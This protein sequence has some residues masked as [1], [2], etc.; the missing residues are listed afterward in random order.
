M[1]PGKIKRR[2]KTLYFDGY[3]PAEIFNGQ[4]LPYQRVRFSCLTADPKL[5]RS[6]AQ[7]QYQALLEKR[8]RDAGPRPLL[9]RE[10]FMQTF[11][12]EWIK[13]RRRKGGPKMAESRFLQHIDPV[14]G[15]LALDQ[16][17]PS[18][19]R[20]LR[21]AL[22]AKKRPHTDRLLSPLTVRH[23]LA[24]VKCL[25]RYAVEEAQVL[26]KS[27][28]TRTLLPPIPPTPRRPL[29]EEQEAAILAVARP[30]EAF[31]IRLAV[32]SGLRWGE[33]RTLHRR[34]VH[35]EP[36]PHL[37][38]DSRNEKTG[39]V[40]VVPLVPEAEAMIQ[41]RLAA[42]DSLM[43]SPFQARNACWFVHR[44]SAQVGFHW[45]FHQTRHAFV[46]RSQLQGYS[47]GWVGAVAGQTPGT[48]GN[49]THVQ[50]ESL[51]AEIDRV[52]RSQNRRND[53]SIIEIPRS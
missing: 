28:V 42:T 4:K 36:R 40:R 17:T 41:D 21:G 38:I 9:V 44:I 13:Q 52:N 14:I 18:D 29:T 10:F 51:F 31:V 12:P 5:A 50:T 34:D 3:A 7:E 37:V 49:Y 32:L 15:D 39:R 33:L 23:V 6:R 16:V 35:W 20:R 11:L 24:D 45:H 25:F 26:D 22:E 1:I 47:P 27:P 19:L 53:A 2:G 43:V 46:T 30:D 8:R 48:V